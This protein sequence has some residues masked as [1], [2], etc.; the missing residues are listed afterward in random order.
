M[1]HEFSVP[2]HVDT[3]AWSNLCSRIRGIDTTY[4]VGEGGGGLCERA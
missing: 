4:K 1:E 3:P 2:L